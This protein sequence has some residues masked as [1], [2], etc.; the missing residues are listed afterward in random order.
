MAN[1]NASQVLMDIIAISVNVHS[2]L[3]QIVK[4]SMMARYMHHT[5]NNEKLYTSRI[6]HFGGSKNV[7]ELFVFLQSAST[8]TVKVL[9]TALVGEA[10]FAFLT[11]TSSALTTLSTGTDANSV[12]TYASL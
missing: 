2:I 6:P 10:A 7:Y 5:I 4:V 12:S 1:A 3:F 8:V 9:P 11:K